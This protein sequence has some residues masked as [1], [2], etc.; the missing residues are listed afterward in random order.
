MKSIILVLGLLPALAVADN[1]RIAAWNL[2]GALAVLAAYRLLQPAKTDSY[3]AGDVTIGGVYTFGQPRVGNQIFSDT[4]D[5]LLSGRYFRAVNNRDIV[6][7]VPIPITPNPLHLKDSSLPESYQYAHCGSV[8]YFN[9]L[10]QAMIDLPVWY[11]G[12]DKVAMPENKDVLKEKLQEA[13][14]DHTM[15]GYIASFRRTIG[16]EVQ[17]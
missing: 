14:G 1:A 10:G 17:G 8:I 2:G 5:T 9:E 16:L 3:K 13:V 15:A 6:P 4:I 7:L 12:L 11:R